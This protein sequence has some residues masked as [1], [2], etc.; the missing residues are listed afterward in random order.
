M[1]RSEV[2]RAAGFGSM[3]SPAGGYDKGYLYDGR[4][5]SRGIER[6]RDR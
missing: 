4:L 1:N 2:A 6:S 5:T 3:R